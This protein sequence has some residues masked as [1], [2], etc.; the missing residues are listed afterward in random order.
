ESKPNNGIEAE[1]FTQNRQELEEIRQALAREADEEEAEALPPSDTAGEREPVRARIERPLLHELVRRTIKDLSHGDTLPTE[2]EVE[3]DISRLL[4]NRPLRP[5]EQTAIRESLKDA[6]HGAPQERTSVR[7][8]IS[9]EKQGELDRRYRELLFS[10]IDPKL[11]RALTLCY[12][13][14]RV[15]DDATLHSILQGRGNADIQDLAL[16]F[17]AG[18]AISGNYKTAEQQYVTALMQSTGTATRQLMEAHKAGRSADYSALEAL[19]QKAE[20]PYHVYIAFQAGEESAGKISDTAKREAQPAGAPASERAETPEA[21]RQ[22]TLAEFFGGGT[23]HRDLNQKLLEITEGVSLDQSEALR[24]AFIN[25][26]YGDPLDLSNRDADIQEKMRQAYAIGI[27]ANR[28]DKTPEQDQN[29]TEQGK[30]KEG[31]ADFQFQPPQLQPLWDRAPD[32]ENPYARTAL[33]NAYDDGSAGDMGRSKS[34]IWINSS[35]LTDAEK[36]LADEAFRIGYAEWEA[37]HPQ[38]AAERRQQQAAR[39][40]TESAEESA[41][42]QDTERQTPQSETPTP[43]ERLMRLQAESPDIHPDVLERAYRRGAVGDQNS[44]QNAFNIYGDF[45]HAD[46]KQKILEAY[47]IGAEAGGHPPFTPE[48]PPKAGQSA[49]EQEPPLETNGVEEPP[50]Q[51]HSTREQTREDQGQEDERRTQ[52]ERERERVEEEEELN[53]LDRKTRETLF[54]HLYDTR[55]AYAEAKLYAGRNEKDP[56]ILLTQSAYREAV[57]AVRDYYQRHLAADISLSA[58][59]RQELM[60]AH[61]LETSASES[62]RLY[63]LMSE[64][65]IAEQKKQ[66]ETRMDDLLDRNPLRFAAEMTFRE[67]P[68]M[69][70]RSA[71]QA[72]EWYRKLPIK[73]KLI[74]SGALFAGSALGGAAMPA[75]LVPI[76]L[77][78]TTQR[79]LAGGAA[80]LGIDAWLQKRQERKAEQEVTAEVETWG[81]RLTAALNRDNH[82]RLNDLMLAQAGRKGRE[83]WTR[84]AIA[85]TAFAAIAT[86]LHGKGIRAGLSYAAGT[87]TGQA[88]LAWTGQTKVAQM[89]MRSLG[90]L[91]QWKTNV[92]SGVKGLARQ[93]IAEAATG[94]H[95]PSLDTSG[96]GRSLSFGERVKKS[97]LGLL[98]IDEAQENAVKAPKPQEAPQRPNISPEVA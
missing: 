57:N 53:F 82:E 90:V 70:G 83:K 84:Y 34:Y 80:A 35:V 40:V 98:G 14:G 89:A 31:G 60:L 19:L 59:D 7:K 46:Q 76:M 20:D 55:R 38:E 97:A 43:Y 3:A 79:A 24:F 88:A 78:M 32:K 48:T 52:E 11:V 6:Q 45:F 29:A 74:V 93:G 5:Q 49:S 54:G 94:E 1:G 96:V 27:E 77:G 22:S 36:R 87:E 12:K 13:A 73:T 61:I 10:A 4:H 25:G 95:I 65:K 18:E 26:L 81:D 15:A 63:D 91:D 44:M 17:Q 75:L 86:G 62:K 72:A 33:H 16:A 66:A 58:E 30:K 21:I 42:R 2:Q 39:G 41:P 9:P 92:M 64:I 56:E 23:F 8:D 51:E 37:T 67:L 85:S 28:R 47:N 68:G 69:V 50:A 71:L